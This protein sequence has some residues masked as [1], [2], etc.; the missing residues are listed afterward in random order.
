MLLTI[1]FP[2]HSSVPRKDV[3]QRHLDGW[4]D[5]WMDGRQ[6]GRERST[7]T[8]SLIRKKT[9]L[10]QSQGLVLMSANLYRNRDSAQIY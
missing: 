8:E 2:D 1:I 5:G 3:R 7:D 10:R 9:V 4:V 6:E